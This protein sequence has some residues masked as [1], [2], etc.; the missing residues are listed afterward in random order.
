MP[1]L[2]DFGRN[3][4]GP[5]LRTAKH[6]LKLAVDT[7]YREIQRLRTLGRYVPGTTALMGTEFRFTDAPTFLASWH[8][9]IEREAYRFQTHHEQPLILDVGAN[10]G[11]SVVYFKRLFPAS[12]VI[13]FEPDRSLFA[14]LTANVNRFGFTDVELIPK[15][16]WSGAGRMGFYAEGSDSGRLE[17]STQAATYDVETVSLRKWLTQP[18]AMLKIDIEGAETEVIK[19]IEPCLALVQHLFV[20][21]HSFSDRPQCLDQLIR[22]LRGA[23]FRCYMEAQPQREFPFIP[24]ATSGMD[25]QAN[26]FAYRE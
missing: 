15:A 5:V 21:Y 13:A 20:E 2:V 18:V 24:P 16:A 1:Q 12:R 4:L 23:A 11:V 6:R 26:I 10:I 3:A 25:F 8:E 9:I 19:D 14:T 22:S 17:H 7:R